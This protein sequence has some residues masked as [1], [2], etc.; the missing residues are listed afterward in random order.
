MSYTVQGQSEELNSQATP[1]L[2]RTAYKHFNKFVGDSKLRRIDFCI[3]KLIKHSH[4]NDDCVRVPF[5]DHPRLFK[6]GDELV[7]FHQ[8]YYCWSEHLHNPTCKSV[9]AIRQES[10]KFAAEHGLT[11]RVSLED[12]WHVPGKTVLVEYRKFAVN[13]AGHVSANLPM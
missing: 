6:R 8:P 4:N 7:F 5:N 13:E 2:A 11:V 1:E 10:E 12:S 3:C 9:E